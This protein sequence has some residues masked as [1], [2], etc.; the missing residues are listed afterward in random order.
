MTASE[1]TLQGTDEHE[2]NTTKKTAVKKVRIALAFGT[3]LCALCASADAPK[4]YMNADDTNSGDAFVNAKWW[5][6]EGGT[7]G[8]PGALPD[9][10]GD[11]YVVGHKISTTNEMLGATCPI[12]FNSLHIGKVNGLTSFF[13][14]R[15]SDKSILKVLGEGLYLHNGQMP[16]QWHPITIDGIVTVDALDAYPFLIY[17]AYSSTTLNI[18][19]TL[20]AG[21]EANLQF[22]A[23][24]NN[25]A[26][27][28]EKDTLHVKLLGDYS[29][30]RGRMIVG[31]DNDTVA[32]FVQ[33]ELLNGDFPGSLVVKTNGEISV[34][35]DDVKVGSCVFEDGSAIVARGGCL[36]VTNDFQAEGT[37]GVSLA[38]CDTPNVENPRA[39]IIS[40]PAGV[41]ISSG[42][43]RVVETAASL[44]C[45]A[46]S[47]TVERDENGG[48]T[49]YASFER[50]SVYVSPN[51]SDDDTGA[52]EDHAF[53]TLAHAV[54]VLDD[55]V[56]Y[57]LPGTYASGVCD[58]GDACTHSRVHIPA[59]VVLKSTEGAEQTFIVGDAGVAP[60]GDATARAGATRCARLDSGAVL[61]G[62]TLTG[63]YV[64]NNDK[65]DPSLK[66]E[67]TGA[68]VI[69]EVGSVVLDCRLY[70]NTAVCGGAA[71]GG[72]YVRC[73]F[74]NIR[75]R[76]RRQVARRS[77]ATEPRSGRKRLR[78]EAEAA[79]L[80]AELAHE[81]GGEG[82]AHWICRR[83]SA[84][85][86]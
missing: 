23:I 4:Y 27:D 11:F 26:N 21:E 44:S 8:V 68:G 2:R 85:L 77:V 55:G 70:E 49:L 64:Y 79:R 38:G 80:R 71:Q 14:V 39:A 13:H 7:P 57:A 33:L 69:G 62:F 43:F 59:K 12:N 17:S 61:Q 24:H 52:D 53:A 58:L 76:R 84:V 42:N 73:R 66:Y 65:D 41:S 20:H 46:V 40:V 25:L 35:S 48:S 45:K 34:G 67:Q 3:L 74:G 32:R 83:R 15:V 31:A 60:Q 29:D 36:V 30:Y 1:S 6:D 5:N 54:S 10:N 86:L 19:A 72:A 22:R 37:V 18:P 28:K 47:F 51:G 81:T 63:G 50:S 75:L 56:I 9:A 78:G 82:V 16:L